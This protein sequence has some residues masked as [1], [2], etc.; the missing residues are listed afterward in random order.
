MTIVKRTI[1]CSVPILT[2]NSEKNLVQCL[3][4][5]RDFDDVFLL[6]G[7]STDKTKEIAALFGVAVYPQQ[8]WDMPNVRIT[9]F[10]EMRRKAVSISKRDWVLYLDSDEYLSA[11]LADEIASM[12]CSNPD[13]NTIYF[14]QK[15]AILGDTIIQHS[16]NYPNWGPRL[17]HKR[18]GVVWKQNK[19]VHEQLFIP[20]HVVPHRLHH[21]FYSYGE[22][23]YQTCIRKD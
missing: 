7:N 23:N 10:S 13:K 6:D 16:F 11:E 15:R 12:V 19:K 9:D 18:S 20:P 4:S 21:A 17:F 2:L 1:S 8:D 14:I 3:E 5:V 22:L